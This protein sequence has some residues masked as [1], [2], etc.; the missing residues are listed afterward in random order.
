MCGQHDR[1]VR[2]RQRTVFQPNKFSSLGIFE[3]ALLAAGVCL[4]RQM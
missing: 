1:S 3:N 2:I 4:G